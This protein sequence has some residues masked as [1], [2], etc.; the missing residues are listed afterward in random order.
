MIFFIARCDACRS[1]HKFQ[2]EAEG[3]AWARAHMSE[4]HPGRS[5]GT[6]YGQIPISVADVEQ[7]VDLM[8]PDRSQAS[9]VASCTVC[10]FQEK[11][12]SFAEAAQLLSQHVSDV[13]PEEHSSAAN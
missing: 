9:P 7:D 4:I 5:A 3:R 1:Q 12:S 13:H 6:S 8:P 2:S 10:G 11:A